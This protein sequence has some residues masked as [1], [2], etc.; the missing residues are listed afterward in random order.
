[1]RSMI[2]LFG[3]LL[4]MGTLSGCSA[5]GPYSGSSNGAAVSFTVM[6]DSELPPD[7]RKQI[8]SWKQT[9]T[10]QVVKVGG[11]TYAVI[12]AGQKP[13][14]GYSVSVESVTRS[15][16][17]VKVVYKVQSPPPGAVTTTVITYPYQVIKLQGAGDLKIVFAKQN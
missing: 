7:L 9:E 6:S 1:M 16:E 10:Q 5:G 3:L 12:T 11:E 8:E 15:G 17:N 14:G 13:S 4:F 2:A